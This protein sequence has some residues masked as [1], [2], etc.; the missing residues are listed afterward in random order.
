MMS[1]VSTDRLSLVRSALKNVHFIIDNK[2][3]VE[4]ARDAVSVFISSSS[5]CFFF[6]KTS[7]IEKLEIEI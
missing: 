1:N 4:L 5:T 3:G 7:S 6:D 2:S